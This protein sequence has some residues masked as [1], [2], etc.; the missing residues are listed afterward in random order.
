[1]RGPNAKTKAP[2]PGL[3]AAANP[4]RTACPG[5]NLEPPAAYRRTIRSRTL[6]ASNN[7]RQGIV[8]RQTV[9]GLGAGPGQAMRMRLRASSISNCRVRPRRAFSRTVDI[10]GATTVT[11]CC[12]T[13]AVAGQLLDGERGLTDSAGY[14]RPPPSTPRLSPLRRGSHTARRSMAAGCWRYCF[15]LQSGCG[16]ET[17]FHRRTPYSLFWCLAKTP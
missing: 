2:Q 9:G 7:Q 12:G 6:C 3:S 16:C 10:C 15:W 17:G 8:W 4:I 11:S 14:T 1:M 13:M 5:L